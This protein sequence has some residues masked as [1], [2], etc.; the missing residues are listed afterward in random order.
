MQGSIFRLLACPGPEQAAHCDVRV[1]V[2]PLGADV[3]G[4]GSV[5]T[6]RAS[7]GDNAFGP[8][9]PNSGEARGP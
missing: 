8:A 5:A 7:A 9:M 3:N 4:R 6:R 1:L 2:L